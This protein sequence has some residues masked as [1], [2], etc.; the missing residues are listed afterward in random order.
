MSKNKAQMGKET[1]TSL[2]FEILQ[3]ILNHY[4][5]IVYRLWNRSVLADRTSRMNLYVFLTTHTH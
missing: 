2:G 5:G 4:I 1:V 3:E